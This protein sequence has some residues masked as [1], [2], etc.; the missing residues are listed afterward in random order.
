MVLCE[1][2]TVFGFGWN[3][4]GQLGLGDFESRCTPVLVDVM[5]VEILMRETQT[6]SVPRVVDVELGRWH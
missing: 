6:H 4:Y 3:K 1:D 5:K 2:G